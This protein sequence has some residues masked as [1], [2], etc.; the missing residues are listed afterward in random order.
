[1][2]PISMMKGI[3]CDNCNRLAATG[4]SPVS[5]MVT[6]L[7]VFFTAL[8]LSSEAY[9]VA[10]AFIQCEPPYRSKINPLPKKLDFK[11]IAKH[12]HRKSAFTQG[13]VYFDGALFESTGL[14]G[15]SSISKINLQNGEILQHYQLN[16]QLFGEGIAIDN[17]YIVQLSWRDG[18]AFRYRLQ[19]LTPIAEYAIDGEGWGI[20]SNGQHFITSDGSAHI[21]WRDRENLE[22]LYSKQVLFAGRPLKHLNELEWVDG[23]LLANVWKSH[24]IAVIEPVSGKVLYRIDLGALASYEE[25]LGPVGVTNGIAYRVFDGRYHLLVTGKHWR[26]IYEILLTTTE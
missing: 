7:L 6:T 4:F 9:T 10:P 15:K 8:S 1:M 21:T 23:C 14:K 19:D 17:G 26:Y 12:P 18:K 22:P 3:P 24:Q 11:V 20:T 5:H 13:L 16:P 25:K 2:R